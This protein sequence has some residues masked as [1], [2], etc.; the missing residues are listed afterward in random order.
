MQKGDEKKI[1]ATA[2]LIKKLDVK[3]FKYHK[4]TSDQVLS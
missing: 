1:A 2:E 3:D 4:L